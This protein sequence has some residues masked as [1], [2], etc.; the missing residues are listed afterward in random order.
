MFALLNLPGTMAVLKDPASLGMDGFANR[1]SHTFKMDI[2]IGCIYCLIGCIYCFRGSEEHG[3]DEKVGKNIFVVNMILVLLFWLTA[4]R[5]CRLSSKIQQNAPYLELYKG[6]VLAI[7][8]NTL[9]TI[10]YIV[11]R[12]YKMLKVTDNNSTAQIVLETAL[13]ILIVGAKFLSI[14]VLI[15]FR[16]LLANAEV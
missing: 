8:A 10:V 15:A 16:K 2:L 11:W 1:F 4:W 9:L 6:S 14:C 13:F 5:F 12:L 3:L 7:F